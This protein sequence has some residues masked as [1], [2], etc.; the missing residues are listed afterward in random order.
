MTELEKQKLGKTICNIT[1]Q[2]RGAMNFVAAV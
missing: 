1:G 2:L